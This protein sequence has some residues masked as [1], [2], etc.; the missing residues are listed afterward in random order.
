MVIIFAV[1]FWRAENRALQMA[2]NERIGLTGIT[3]LTR[4]AVGYARF[5]TGDR[6]EAK[7]IATALEDYSKS[8]AVAQFFSDKEKIAR[9]STGSLAVEALREAWGEV[10]KSVDNEATQ[11]KFEEQLQSHVSFVANIS[12]LVL[13]PNLN[14]FYLMDILV[15]QIPALFDHLNDLGHVAKYPA[16][17]QSMELK[18]VLF[19]SAEA[20]LDHPTL[21]LNNGNDSIRFD[22]LSSHPSASLKGIATATKELLDQAS[23]FSRKLNELALGKTA[24]D[25][26]L[27]KEE[28]RQFVGKLLDVQSTV[29]RELDLLLQQEM[30]SLRSETI[31]ALALLA[32]LCAAYGLLM[33]SIIRSIAV[34]LQR[35]LQVVDALIHGRHDVRMAIEGTDE[36]TTLA[37]AFGIF[38][39][40]LALNDKDQAEFITNMVH[41][42]LAIN[43]GVSSMVANVEELSNTSD[44]L[45]ATASSSA[46]SVEEISASA[47]E[48]GSR[49]RANSDR[50]SKAND[51]ASKVKEAAES[52][53]AEARNLGEAMVASQ[54]AGQKIVG[55]VKIIDEIAFQTNLLALNAAVEAA[56]AGKHGKGFAV[57]A[58][59]VRNLAGRSARSAKETTELIEGVVAKMDHAA[60][61]AGRMKTTLNQIVE[62]A[63]S[64]ASLMSDIATASQEQAEAVTQLGAGLS[65]IEEIAQNNTVQAETATSIAKELAQGSR[66]LSELLN[67]ESSAFIKWGP[68]YSVGVKAMDDQHLVLVDFINNLHS[69]TVSGK[70]VAEMLPVVGDLVSYARRH[71]GDEEALLVRHSYPGHGEQHGLHEKLI[72]SIDSYYQ[73][74]QRGEKINL[75][76]FSNFLKSW[77]LIHIKNTDMKYK[78]YLNAK[79]VY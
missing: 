6:D 38:Q 31:F 30:D 15:V 61:S 12:G 32:L 58:D 9:Y 24:F 25:P 48:I 5:L 23:G 3:P 41:Y 36:F 64:M 13:D 52:G 78:P 74:M 39:E 54:E 47:S 49:T 27:V 60:Q 62:R 10:E 75:V 14:S 51:I 43:R 17:E 59:E 79:G 71:F 53:D 34:P 72:G 70:E 73:R 21:I 29:A 1:A 35:A 18:G 57:V 33:F 37:T 46:A 11:T 19:V 77:L 69:M 8:E 42:N 63:V 45:A 28:T 2:R 55:V 4:A 67:R 68:E 76:E 56:R 50:S 26:T 16:G 7:A 65:Q 44:K 20:L 66:D 40:R 22:A